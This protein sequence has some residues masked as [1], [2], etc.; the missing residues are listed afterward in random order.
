MTPVLPHSESNATSPNEGDQRAGRL[1]AACETLWRLEDQMELVP[2]RC[3]GRDGLHLWQV[4]RFQIFMTALRR[5]GI[6]EAH[7]PN[8]DD[9]RR[10]S[11]MAGLRRRIERFTLTPGRRPPGAQTVFIATARKID[12]HDPLMAPLIEGYRDTSLSVFDT[13]SLGQRQKGVYDLNAFHKRAR[14]SGREILETTAADRR[15]ASEFTAKLG[16]AL[17]ADLGDLFA[18]MDRIGTEH[19]RLRSAWARYFDVCRAERLIAVGS[20]FRQAAFAG[21]RMTGIDAVDVQHG[22][23]SRYEVGYSWPGHPPSEAAPTGMVFFGRHWVDSVPHPAALTPVVSGSAHIE[24]LLDA[25][26]RSESGPVD[27]RGPVLVVGQR[28]VGK[29]LWTFAVALARA[30]PGVP[31]LYRPHPGESIRRYQALFAAEPDP[32]ANLELSSGPLGVYPLIMSARLQIG[33]YSTTL[34]EGLV[35]GCPSVVLDAPGAEHMDDVVARGDM[36]M[37][38]TIEEAASLVAAPPAPR[39]GQYYFAP[40]MKPA[41]IAAALASG[42]GERTAG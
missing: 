28:T 20:Y 2:W 4:M 5:A 40:P 19:L 26:K 12:G 7:Q 24:G 34:F 33:V 10:S 29:I 13:D 14:Q 36:R 9:V 37:V 23:I 3:G 16:T 17:S 30:C 38:S 35:L 27:P 32:P 41:D 21:A 22:M 11:L 8:P 1:R 25:G 15:R 6:L 18:D 39:N 42:Q 31:V